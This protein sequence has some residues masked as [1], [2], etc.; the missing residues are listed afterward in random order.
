MTSE[1]DQDVESTYGPAAPFSEH[2]R[3]EHITYTSAEGLPGA[4]DI[5]WVCAAG[6]VGNQ[7]MGVRYIVAPDPPTGFVDI[8]WPADIRSSTEREGAS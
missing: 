2:K 5:V 4:G 8:V 6:M 1:Q 3:G 7:H